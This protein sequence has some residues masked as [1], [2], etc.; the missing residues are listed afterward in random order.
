MM[1]VFTFTREAHQRLTHAGEITRRP[2]MTVS[3][4]TTFGSL[5]STQQPITTGP[6]LLGGIISV[7][8][9]IS[10]GITWGVLNSQ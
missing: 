2:R 7:R 4:K 5:A 10:K 9:A 8:L 6:P 1:E 3:V